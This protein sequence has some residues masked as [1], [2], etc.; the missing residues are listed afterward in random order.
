[1]LWNVRLFRD[2]FRLRLNN[3]AQTFRF[4]DV[5]RQAWA[6]LP[7]GCAGS[8]TA[9]ITCDLGGTRV[10]LSSHAGFGQWMMLVNT[11]T[12]M[13]TGH[14]HVNDEGAISVLDTPTFAFGLPLPEYW[15]SKSTIILGID[16]PFTANISDCVADDEDILRLKEGRK[17]IFVPARY[18]KPT[19]SYDYTQPPIFSTPPELSN[20][21]SD[22][23]D[24]MSAI[25]GP[26]GVR[27]PSSKTEKI[28][29]VESMVSSDSD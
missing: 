15:Q 27:P 28:E 7:D 18:A 8:L 23:D 19:E 17:S 21:G 22:E 1:M 14:I 16:G 6:Q 12:N 3:D 20:A 5:H 4:Y 25:D 24:M 2:R 11:R 10:K 13:V 26:S 9:N 29:K